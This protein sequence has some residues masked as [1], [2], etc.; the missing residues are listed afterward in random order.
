MPIMGWVRRMV[1]GM[2]ADPPTR[3]FSSG[4]MPIDRMFAEMRG[5]SAS[6]GREEALQ[7]PGVVRGRNL[8]CSVATLPL[9]E[10]GPNN[11]P[12]RAPLLEQIDPNVPNVVVL[13]A[14]FEDLMFEGKSW[15]QVTARGAD[16]YPVNARHLAPGRVSLRPPSTGF[17]MPRAV[18]PPPTGRVWVDGKEVPATD[19]IRFD[20]PNPGLLSYAGRTLRLAAKYQRAAA[21]YADNPQTSEHFTPA[22][23]AEEMTDDEVREHLSGW[24]AARREGATGYVPRGL[25]YNPGDPVSAA[26]QKL[27]ELKQQ[28]SLEA[29]LCMGLDPEVLGVPV[30][31]RTY[32]NRQDFARDRINDMFAPYMLAVTQRLSMMDVC[33]RGYTRVFD[34]DDYLRA[35]P[36]TRVQYYQGMSG[37]GAIDVEYIQNEEGLPVR[38][39]L[40]PAAPT[41]AAPPADEVA[42]ARDRRAAAFDAPTSRQFEFRAASFSADVATRTIR[43]IALPYNEIASKYGVRFRF[44]PGSIEWAADAVGR[45]KFLDNHDYAK[46]IGV[47]TTI[48]NTDAGLQTAFKVGAGPERDALL[49]DAA[50]GIVDGLSVGVEFDDAVDTVPDPD[51]EGVLLVRRA[52]L[53]EVSLTAM[54]AFDSARVTT[55]A[56]RRDNGGAMLCTAC[57]QQMTPGVAHV[58]PGP[59]NGPVTLTAEQFAAL[60]PAAAPAPVPADPGPVPVDPAG[61]DAGRPAVVLSEPLAYRFDRSGRNFAVGQEHDFSTDVVAMLKRGDG[62]GM[63][64]D[65]GRRVMTFIRAQF[66]VDSADINEVTPEIQRPDMY[67]DQRDYRYPLW[68]SIN[69][70]APPNGV[71]PFRFP[72]FSS[73]SGLV[74]AHTEGTEPSGG[75]LVTTSTP[76]APTSISGKAYITREVWDMGGN[77]A[78]STLIWNQMVRGYNEALETATATF[79][80]TLTAAADLLLTAG[81]VDEVLAAVWEG[82]VADLQFV[83]GYDFEFFAVEKEL[84]KRFA[85]AKDGAERP[86]YPMINPMN[87]NGQS[88]RR[89]AT[90]DLAGV[91]GIPSWALASTAGS[92]NN[93]WLYDPSTVHGW[94][95]QP[96]RLEFEG[97]A[98]DNSTVAPVAKLGLG[99]W[100]YS[101][102]INSDI[103][104]VRQ[105]IYDTVA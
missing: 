90:L 75:T 27:V 88:R 69:K 25:Q 3:Q 70:G 66:D 67:V 55:V 1:L 97:A 94:A 33:R 14:T 91:E 102:F 73:A 49:Q 72:K 36:L 68:N 4:P 64:T 52:T 84:F 30:T 74:A 32:A 54:P 79:L 57:G 45:V 78:V 9:L 50:D 65:E 47:A 15:W 62:D 28:A 42:A 56:A 59:T 7:I 18:D 39:S 80:N 23:N 19:M 96:Q 35:D 100:G 104:G 31:S 58:C 8:L 10:R 76:V 29:A 82:H 24:R 17:G 40:A 98:D 81:A 11:V 85:A 89:F 92:P 51:H 103:G 13:S 38:G 93:S 83:R 41:P 20:S 105:V 77:P 60:F 2:P 86:L 26:D 48:T 34:L 87:A 22:P 61:P 53:R 37:L 99:I 44:A 101:A 5:G 16:R 6:I 71:Q 95:T 63:N 21:M 43:G 12:V 46:P